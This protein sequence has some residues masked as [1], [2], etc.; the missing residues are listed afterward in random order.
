MINLVTLLFINVLFAHFA[1]VT[2][3]HWSYSELTEALGGCPRGK[4]TRRTTELRQ[5]DDLEGDNEADE[6]DDDDEDDEN[7][8]DDESDNARPKK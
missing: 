3:T 5:R 4:P 7:D 6:A 1:Q 2:Y 8:H